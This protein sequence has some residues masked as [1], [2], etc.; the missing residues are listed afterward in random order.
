MRV[1]TLP[2]FMKSTFFTFLIFIPIV[3]ATAM[4]FTP[5]Y[6]ETEQDGFSV[7]RLYF[8]DQARRVYLSVPNGWQVAGDP[9]RG[10]LTPKDLGQATVILENSPLNAKTPFTGESL[11]VYRKT[12]YGLVPPGATDVHTDFERQGE[13]VINGWTSFE[14]AFTYNFYGQT[15]SS[16]VLFINL[17]K[18]KQIRFRVSA[19]K[20]N[21][22]KLYPQARSTLASWFAPSPELETV[23]QQR[24]S[25]S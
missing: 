15:F 12:A 10:T 20:E 22:E 14:M 11:E 16:S 6:A 21:F 3:G 18:E 1:R 9:Q 5:H 25:G 17:D 7:K 13:V 4:D 2:T 24:S 19:R 23:M 8:L